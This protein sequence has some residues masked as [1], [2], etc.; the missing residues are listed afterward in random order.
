MCTV[1]SGC[2][3][4]AESVLIQDQSFHKLLT[5][6]AVSRSVPRVAGE[7]EEA[8]VQAVVVVSLC[9]AAVASVA[10]LSGM[11]TPE[12]FLRLA[13]FLKSIGVKYVIDLSAGMIVCRVNY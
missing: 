7:M 11:T 10:A 12:A 1:S 3:T 9:P 5:A 4:S 13:S 6:L 2:I 8:V